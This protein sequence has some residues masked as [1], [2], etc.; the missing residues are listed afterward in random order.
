M[1]WRRRAAEPRD[2]KPATPTRIK[3][4]RERHD[5][6]TTGAH[7][8]PAA[9]E[10]TLTDAT[11]SRCGQTAQ[12]TAP[13]DRFMLLRA[14]GCAREG[15]TGKLQRYDLVVVG[16]RLDYFLNYLPDGKAATGNGGGTYVEDVAD[17]KPK[18]L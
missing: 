12:F 4:D 16:G 6:Q 2:A 11:C 5:W 17:L 3:N 9:P 13:I 15:F 8:H 18:T 1:N 10:F 14:W 7:P